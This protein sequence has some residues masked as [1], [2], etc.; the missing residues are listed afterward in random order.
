MIT[1]LNYFLR[2]FE[3]PQDFLIPI[4]GVMVLWAII[5]ALTARKGIR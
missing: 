2:I 1:Y 5:S 4:A 3:M